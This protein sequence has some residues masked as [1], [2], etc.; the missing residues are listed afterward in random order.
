MKMI[1]TIIIGN[2][3]MKKGAIKWEVVDSIILERRSGGDG[4]VGGTGKTWRRAS[5]M[6]CWQ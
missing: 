4:G 5:F 2:H 6:P 3:R 1:V